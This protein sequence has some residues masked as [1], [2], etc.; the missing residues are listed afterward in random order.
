MLFAFDVA[1]A[2]TP[3]DELVVED[4]EATDDETDEDISETQETQPN[5]Q[6]TQ[7][8]EE[9]EMSQSIL[10]SATKDSERDIEKENKVKKV[11]RRKKTK[12]SRKNKTQVNIEKFMVQNKQDGSVQKTP[13]TNVKNLRNV[14]EKSPV[15][16]PEELHERENNKKKQKKKLCNYSAFIN[17]T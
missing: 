17:M 8:P 11:G 5:S 10:G 9:I 6:D 4:D 7:K 13:K 16:P 2:E 3:D 1:P 15:T 14:F 12:A